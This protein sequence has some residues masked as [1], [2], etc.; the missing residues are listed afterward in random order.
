MI[1]INAVTTI[2]LVL[3][4]LACVSCLALVNTHTWTSVLLLKAVPIVTLIFIGIYV[5]K[6]L[7]V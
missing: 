5:A 2:V 3:S 1:D 7:V 4:A 6:V